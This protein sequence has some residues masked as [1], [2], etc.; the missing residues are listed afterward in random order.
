MEERQFDQDFVEYIVKAIVGHPDDVKTE[1]RIDEKGVLITL[2]INPED[3]GYVIGRQG[4]T[5]R[6]IRTLLKTVGA[7]NNARVNLKIFEP[8]G[9]RRPSRP[10][11]SSNED[12]DTSAV[13]L[14][15]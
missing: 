14:K 5:A 4:N 15:I 6:A 10:V 1:R 7:K 8:E 2:F 11:S 12:I 13:D 3:M 9:S